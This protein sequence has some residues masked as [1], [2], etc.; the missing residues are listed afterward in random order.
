MT[1]FPYFAFIVVIQ[2][3]KRKRKLKMKIENNLAVLLSHN[4]TP[5]LSFL[6]P[7]IFPTICNMDQPCCPFHCL[8]LSTPLLL[9]FLVQFLL[10]SQLFLELSF[11]FLVDSSSIGFL[12]IF[13]NFFLTFPN[14]SGHISYLSIQIVFLL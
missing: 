10:L 2:L 8:I 11:S 6:V 14:I 7:R 12:F 5:L 4:T 3:N 13:S 1:P 9:I